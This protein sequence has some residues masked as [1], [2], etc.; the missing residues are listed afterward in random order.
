M[1]DAE[2]TKNRATIHTHNP[3]HTCTMISGIVVGKTRVE[4]IA[5]MEAQKWGRSR[6]VF[7]FQAPS[8]LPD[9]CGIVELT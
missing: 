3:L 6:D 2:N 5:A 7:F 8:L 9:V 1:L 4:G